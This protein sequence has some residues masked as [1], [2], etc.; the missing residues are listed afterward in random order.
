MILVCFG[1]SFKPLNLCTCMYYSTLFS[2][3]GKKVVII[4]E[5]D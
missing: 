4:V 5:E 3:R 2:V 1:G